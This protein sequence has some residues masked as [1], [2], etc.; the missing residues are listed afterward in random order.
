MEQEY[1]AALAAIRKICAEKGEAD[2]IDLA[3]TLS[4]TAAGAEAC[5]RRLDEDGLAVV[6]EIDLCCGE[7]YVVRGL[8]EKGEA[9][10]RERG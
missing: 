5:I 3:K 8:T 4:I 10:L 7:E 9:L 6:I 2:A 1:S